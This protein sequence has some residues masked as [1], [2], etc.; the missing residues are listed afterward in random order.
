MTG[1]VPIPAGF[2]WHEDEDGDRVLVPAATVH[3]VPWHT[4]TTAQ[5]RT[6]ACAGAGPGDGPVAAPWWQVLGMPKAVLTALNA[7]T[8]LSWY[9]YTRN[10]PRY[11]LAADYPLVCAVWQ[12]AAWLYARDPKT[13]LGHLN[14]D[15]PRNARSARTG[16]CFEPIGAPFVYHRYPMDV[17][18]Q[19]VTHKA[20]TWFQLVAPFLTLSFTTLDAAT[21]FGHAL[22]WPLGDGGRWCG[23]RE[24]TCPLSWHKTWKTY[25]QTT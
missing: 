11:A 1:V 21:T 5:G 25:F 2:V 19:R 22:G 20:H 15:V 8:L 7:A 17:A 10:N 13:T 24:P 18:L 4:F 12:G 16:D 23:C 14:V 6:M 3:T 9:R